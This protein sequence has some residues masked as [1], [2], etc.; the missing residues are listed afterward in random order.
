MHNVEIWNCSQINTQKAS[1]RFEGA[2]GKWS[3]IK[4]V[5]IHNGHGWG[6]HIDKSAN[7]KVENM[8]IFTHK[9]IGF[10]AQTSQNITVDGSIVS[11]IYERSDFGGNGVRVIDL[12]AAYTMCGIKERDPCINT[13]LTNN[14]AAGAA[15]AGFITMGHDCGDIN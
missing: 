15:Y 9:P 12:R 6:M 2:T 4:G 14:I 3:H 8:I 1:L 10:A 7:I 11:N 13:Y 5:S